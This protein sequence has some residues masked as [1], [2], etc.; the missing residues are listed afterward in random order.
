M[1]QNLS[2]E[3]FSKVLAIPSELGQLIAR[4]RD[5]DGLCT[6]G[7]YLSSLDAKFILVNPVMSKGKMAIA[8]YCFECFMRV[9]GALK[10]CRNRGYLQKR[11]E[12][13]LRG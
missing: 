4:M 5:S 3:P 11:S 7:R 1:I 12:A 6:C 9:N 10:E 2:R 8:A 13:D